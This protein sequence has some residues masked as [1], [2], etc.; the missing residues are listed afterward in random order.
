M[1]IV[2]YPF[3]KLASGVEK[4]RFVP[5]TFVEHN[6]INGKNKPLSRLVSHNKNKG[7]RGNRWT[8][9]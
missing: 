4:L 6:Y 9:V 1:I 5:Y 8:S 7:Q 3:E 2:S